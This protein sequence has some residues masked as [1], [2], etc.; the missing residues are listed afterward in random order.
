M[1]YLFLIIFIQFNNFRP[2]NIFNVLYINFIL[3]YILFIHMFVKN[4]IQ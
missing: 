3:Y 4:T 1:Q 2:I